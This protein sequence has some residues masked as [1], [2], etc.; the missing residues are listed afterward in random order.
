MNLQ[1]HA[2]KFL[3][4]MTII[5]TGSMPSVVLAGSSGERTDWPG[6]RGPR[7]DGIARVGSVFSTS[8]D[9]GLKIEWKVSI[10]S[11][12]SGVAVAQGVA[13]TMFS[14]GKSDVLAAY[15]VATGKQRWRFP[16]EDTYV[17]H[18]GSHTGP[19]AT[20]VIGDEQVYGLGAHGRLFALNLKNGSLAW[21]VDLVKDHEAPKPHYGFSTSPMLRDGILIVSGGAKGAVAVGFDAKTGKLL[22][23]SGEDKVDYQSPVAYNRNGVTQILTAGKKKLTAFSPQTGEVAWQFEHQGTGAIGAGSL[24]AVPVGEDRLFLTNKDQSSCV[25]ALDGSAE[26]FQAKLAWESKS[27][28]NSYNVPVYH[29]GHIYAFSSRF[30]TCVDANTG[31]AVWRSRQPGDG[32]LILVDGHLVIGTKKTGRLHIVK[33]TPNGYEQRAQ[34]AVFDDLIWANPSFADGSI[35]V[36]SLGELA[37]VNIYQS[38]SHSTSHIADTGGTGSGRFSSFL[39]DIATA[40]NKKAI[41]DQFMSSISEFPLIEGD[42]RVHFLYRGPGSDLAIGSDI[43]GARQEGAM[44]RITGTDLFYRSAILEADARVNYMFIRDYEDHIVDPNNPRKTTSLVYGRE[45]EMNFRGP[46]LDMSWMAMPKWRAPTF[47]ATPDASKQGRLDSRELDSKVL[48]SKLAFDVYL[49]AGYDSS[50]SRYPVAYIHDGDKAITHGDLPRALDNLIGKSVRPL[51]AVFMKPTGRTGVNKFAEMM[52]TELIPYI[53]ANFRTISSREARAN[54]GS[55]FAGFNAV[56]CGFANPELIGKIGTES[57]FMF[58]SMKNQLMPLIK[59]EKE[60]PLHFFLEWGK[61]DLRNP[62]E[63]WDLGQTNRDFVKLLRERGFKPSGGELHDGTGWS[64]WRNRSQAMFSSL[65]PIQ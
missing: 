32:F 40:K 29:D 1:R 11:G 53:D 23:Q 26:H 22:W 28:R 25:Y 17:G 51:I 31:E 33:A 65:F 2:N 9:L 62:D 47:L 6:F 45:M 41:V 52:A 61:Y 19:I 16:F 18:D 15:D 34:L 8:N 49:P 64:S 3:S 50:S 36:R 38:S 46:A 58:G 43:F 24:T 44:T 4:L 63:A 10:G 14:D 48:E 55:G 5:L 37:R 30:L 20:P 54:I 7:G 21:S 39:K 60:Q 35:F 12:Y 59:T 57:A 27:I 56:F 42:T 13:V